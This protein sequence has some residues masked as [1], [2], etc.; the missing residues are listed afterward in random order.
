M[1]AAT[2]GPGAGSGSS[3]VGISQRMPPTN[4]QAEQALLGAIMANSKAY[5][6][7]AE[8]L[9]AD[10]FAD[11]VHRSIYTAIGRLLAS[12]GV[13]DGVMLSRYFA[14]SPALDEVGGTKYIAEL[15]GAM[16]GIINA[17]EYAH[18]IV[19]DW[20]RRELI[21][22]GETLVNGAFDRSVQV[23]ELLSTAVRG[24]DSVSMTGS[25]RAPAI[26]M[27]AA[28][29]EAIARA[30]RASTGK[31]RGGLL[32]GFPS[33]DKVYNGM[34]DGTLH[35]IGARPGMGKS[36][37]AWQMAIHAGLACRDGHAKGG[38]FVQSLEMGAG[39][40]GE[41]ALSAFGAIPAELLQRGEIQFQR[42]AMAMAREELADLPLDIDETAGLSMVQI[43]L[44]AREA[45]RKFGRLALV[46]V[47]HLHIV[48]YDADAG[49][50][51][52]GPTQAV[53]E[54]SRGLKKLAKDLHCPVVALAQLSRS[55]ESR[56]DKRPT[57]SDLRQSGDIEQDADSVA[58]LY[59]P[60]YYIPKD[61]PEQKV[62]ESLQTWQTRVRDYDEMKARLA[63]K[64]EVIFEKVRGGRPQ[65]V[66]MRWDG[67]TTSFADRGGY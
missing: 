38:V 33:L 26:S 63:G 57:L 14:D 42:H 21:D 12:G 9:T 58:F 47:D 34:L 25:T 31:G 13:A 10:H 39:E 30:E 32:T 52:F 8:F 20:V 37:L 19:D 28:M 24:L 7:V 59:R 16:V 6:A 2:R 54:I 64:A 49:K 51:G 17:K 18:A 55:V 45:H 11:P 60:E 5:H 15:L 53:G 56:D 61:A 3:L 23:T 65:L 44:R 66:R 43:A 27:N 4:L 40:L 29:D 41:R 36:A 35:I 48:S 22:A 46:L 62:N 50:R 1:S 67:E